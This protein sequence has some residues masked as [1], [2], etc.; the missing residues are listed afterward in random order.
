MYSYA[1]TYIH[2]Y[3]KFHIGILHVGIPNLIIIIFMYKRTGTFSAP[4]G[5]VG[6]GMPV[7][8]DDV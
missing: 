5:G 6:G 8:S 4:W 3:M 1:H 2:T 7:M